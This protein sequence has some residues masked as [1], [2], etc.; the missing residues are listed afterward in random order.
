MLKSLFRAITIEETIS[1]K[2]P[3]I[4]QVILV[5]ARLPSPDKLLRDIERF[6]RGWEWMK[7]VEAYKQLLAATVEPREHASFLREIGFCLRRAATQSSTVADFQQRMQEAVESYRRAANEF[8]S[9]PEMHT[10]TNHCESAALVCGSQYARDPIEKQRILNEARM[11]EIEAFRLF[12]ENRNAV[13]AA[14]SCG[15][16]LEIAVELV[17][18][19]SDVV[20]NQTVL[21]EG[22]RAWDAL[23]RLDVEI[24]QR[25]LAE[26]YSWSSWLQYQ[27]ALFLPDDDRRKSS[28]NMSLEHGR[29]ATKLSLASEDD[30]SIAFSNI[31]LAW[32]TDEFAGDTDTAEVRF[33]DALASAVK[34]GDHWLKAYA[35]YGLCFVSYW[36]M[37][38]EED[39]EKL[40][41]RSKE[42]AEYARR[43]IEEGRLVN[44]GP[45][46]ALAYALGLAENY[47]N[48]AR[49]ESEGQKQTE[50]LN[51]AIKMARKAVQEARSG[52]SGLA[53]SLS[54]HSLSKVLHFLAIREKDQSEK[55]SM[56]GDALQTR[57]ESIQ[58]ASEATPFF[59]WNL[60]VFHSY[61]AR[62]TADLA[63]D[64]PD[65]SP[66]LLEDAAGTMKECIG[67]CRKAVDTFPDEQKGPLAWYLSWYSEIL[68]KLYVSNPKPSF[69]EEARTALDEA[70]AVY[71]K[72]G[73]SGNAARMKWQVARIWGD[74]GDLGRAGKAFEDASKA[75]EV[76]ASKTPRLSRVYLE[77]STLMKAECYSQRAR[78]ADR[79]GRNDEAGELFLSTSN[80][81]ETSSDWQL[82]APFYKASAVVEQA[83][84]ASKMEDLEKAVEQFQRARSIFREVERRLEEGV[85][86][87]K[88]EDERKAVSQL[89]ADAG[90]RSK[91]CLARSDL[92]EGKLQSRNLGR[93]RGLEK[94]ARAKALFE[95]VASGHVSQDERDQLQ[96]LAMF[97]TAEEKL[98][99]GNETAQPN[100]YAE[101]SQIFQTITEKTRTR[102]V[103]TLALGQVCYCKAME[104]GAKYLTG[105]GPVFFDEAKMNL[106]RAIR[107]Y[108]DAGSGK[109]A[110]WAEA[111]RSYLDAHAFLDRAETAL[112]VS[113][114]LRHYAL[115]ERCLSDAANLFEKAGYRSKREEAIKSLER[116]KKRK[117]FAVSLQNILASPLTSSPVEVSV[118]ASHEIDAIPSPKELERP[119]VQGMINVPAEVEI[120]AEF[121]VQFD[122]VNAGNT[123]AVLVKLENAFPKAWSI[124]RPPSRYQLVD[125][126]VNLAG[127]KLEPVNTETITLIAR[128]DEAGYF[129]MRPRVVFI[130]DLGQLRIQELVAAQVTVLAPLVLNLTRPASEL[131][132]KSLL[133]AFVRDHRD[134][135][136][137]I[138]KA[139]W[140][141]MV[142][143]ARVA[144][145]PRSSLYGTGGRRG[146]AVSELQR[147]GLAEMRIFPGERGRG[148][149][150]VKIRISPASLQVQA[151]LRNLGV[152]IREKYS[153]PA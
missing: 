64:Q 11:E 125:G 50:H 83:E 151:H 56:L 33:R 59:Y 122:L 133:D 119:N 101:A 63:A 136:I 34:T 106:E 114:R 91:Y 61:L 141:S 80:L 51:E 21:Q 145:V 44:C 107:A 138:E 27:A 92:E 81:L 58:K 65:D 15:S 73:S 43:A 115:A 110:S 72:A 48:L 89:I 143:V 6:R 132:F 144:G 42:C 76:A 97:C 137:F 134:R 105:Q 118:G 69:L 62:I 109:A 95:Q 46:V 75:F 139:G 13:G 126:S 37:G 54:L 22:L 142:E 3:Q 140:R 98:A 35:Y 74:S 66:R 128:P 150:I 103:H 53:L 152:K 104:N 111:T 25:I 20:A 68:A 149:R 17:N 108:S 112:E 9:I 82:F 87:D 153:A 94:F 93:S 67:L 116:V 14:R 84:S 71:E 147:K 77:Y 117:R 40:K 5:D 26:L 38:Q 85:R 120:G 28:G 129:E 148:G 19:Q 18:I 29:L 78:L 7:A 146:P 88:S 49:L 41:I 45:I 86:T 8:N 1:P 121:E 60:G 113:E 99:L 30:Y 12:V 90:L 70:A 102:S 57:K 135:E 124:I 31:R 2:T 47:Y 130:D 131:I 52:G 39:Y 4:L 23:L 79:E 96:V 36:R 100:A 127:R 55:T 123:L 16:L 10:E 32:A 24:G